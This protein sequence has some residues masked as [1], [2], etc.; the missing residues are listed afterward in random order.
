[1]KI[2]LVG[3]GSREFGPA[4]IRDILL[5]DIL[6]DGPIEIALVDIDPAGLPRARAYTEAVAEKLHRSATVTS[7]TRVADAL[8]GADAVIL[9]IEINRY[10]YWAQDFHVPRAFGFRQIYG[11]NGG[12][13]GLFHALRNMGPTLEVARAMERHC[14]DAWLVNYTNP[15]TKLCE[16]VNRL[17]DVRVRSACATA[18]STASS[19][20]RASWNSL[21][22]ASTPGRAASITSPGSNR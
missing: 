4:S 17:S 11:E 9:S 22:S 20:W 18:S 15:L 19:R 12:P 14:P 13:G 8:P 5:S 10:F 6:C 2:V 7:T 16:A 3:A 1:M 21:P